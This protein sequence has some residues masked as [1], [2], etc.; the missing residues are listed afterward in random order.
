[1]RIPEVARFY[2]NPIVDSGLPQKLLP[3]K[4]QMKLAGD[5]LSYKQTTA[6]MVKRADTASCFFKHEL[7]AEAEVAPDDR[8]NVFWMMKKKY[9]Y[10]GVPWDVAW[11]IE[12]L[13]HNY[14]TVNALATA[15]DDEQI[16]KFFANLPTG[17]LSMQEMIAKVT[18][19]Q[20]EPI[21]DLV[22]K[23]PN[24]TV[25]DVYI[26]STDRVALMA[27]EL[28]D[29]LTAEDIQSI[30]EKANELYLGERPLS[31]FL[32]GVGATYG[33]YDLSRIL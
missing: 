30:E 28:A 21:T 4:E 10:D 11:I 18:K 25:Y 27:R 23:V 5:L 14:N 16:T 9:F 19:R 32:G 2:R 3:T 33:I 1:M 31:T 22:Y 13:S 7:D 8:E 17:G 15:F 29:M 6:I 24:G 20:F 12:W 26:E